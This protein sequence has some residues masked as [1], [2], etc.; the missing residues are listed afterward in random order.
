[1]DVDVAR[2]PWPWLELFDPG[3]PSNCAD[4]RRLPHWQVA[5]SLFATKCPP[6]S[7]EG[8]F[9][10]A[11]PKFAIAKRLRAYT[12]PPIAAHDASGASVAYQCAQP[13]YHRWPQEFPQLQRA[14]LDAAERQIVSVVLAD[15]L[16]M[17]GPVRRALREDLPMMARTRKGRVRARMAQEALDRHTAG[18][19]RVAI[20][21]AADFFGSEVHSSAVGERVFHRALAGQTMQII[22]PGD[23]PH[24]LTFVDDFGRT[25]ALLGSD[26]RSYGAV[27]HVPNA[28]PMTLDAFAGLVSSAA[29]L[30]TK[31]THISKLA[32]RLAG[33]GLPAARELVEI[34][35]QFDRP[36]IVDD[37]KI[38]STFSI[39]PTPIELAIE[40]TVAVLRHPQAAVAAG[41]TSRV[42]AAIATA[43]R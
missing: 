10:R 7:R 38:R 40:R 39:N 12:M 33:I 15:N 43:A 11:R 13:A 18:R 28:P 5:N 14:I 3:Q 42:R 17:Y 6:S 22:G 21:R 29:A 31:V 20:V 19:V 2:E 32:L 1:M 41:I 37:N 36:F 34:Y 27:W 26:D 25:L 35:Y 4:P 30:P 23:Q 8:P 16:Y 9:T 24:S